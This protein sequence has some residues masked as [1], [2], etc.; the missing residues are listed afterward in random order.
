V[1]ARAALAL[2]GVVALTGCGGD[3]DP[4]FRAFQNGANAICLRYHHRLA[5]LGAP[6]TLA[7]IARVARGAAR[8]GAQERKA[9]RALA[10]PDDAVGDFEQMLVGFDRADALFPAGRRAAHR[11]D[12]ARTRALVERGRAHVAAANVHANELGLTDC[13]RD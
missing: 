2:L 9:L 3:A 6:T 4:G 7:K 13:R 5:R 10:A 11:K 1:R 12:A 8:L